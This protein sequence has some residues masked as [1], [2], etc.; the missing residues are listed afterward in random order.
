M[1]GFI[2]AGLDGSAESRA[3]AAWAADE[4][5]RRGLPLR[6]LLACG[7]HP[8]A[9]AYG[10]HPADPALLRHWAQRIPRETAAA[11][12]GSHQGLTV[13]TEQVAG[14]PVQA[15]LDAAADS[16]M[17]VLGSR[18]L[19]PVGR[20]LLGS[21]SLAVTARARTPVVVV[22]AGPGVVAAV[23][24][25]VVVGIDLARPAEEV[26]AFAFDTA[27][28]RAVGLRVVHGRNRPPLYGEQVAA[29][30]DVD[31]D[32][33]LA[34]EEAE[35]FTRVLR[36]WQEKFPAVTMTGHAV[37]GGPARHLVEAAATAGL[38]VIGRRA[39]TAK[40]GPHLGPVAHA[41]L[42]HSLAPVAVVPH[43]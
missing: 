31:L 9:Y 16:Q 6:L 34:G 35:E 24:G 20:C 7:R 27:A 4:A 8:G 10:P 14:P 23:D 40:V 13:V 28:R 19:G 15:L 32:G 3:A 18:A 26:A 2:T 36:P 33:E 39:V 43:D 17:L 5:L 37:V 22:R 1:L 29:G 11:L 38:L 21:V 41:A 30:L 42:H 25:D 12:R